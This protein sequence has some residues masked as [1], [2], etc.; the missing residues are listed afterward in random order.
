MSY[1]SHLY[2]EAQCATGAVRSSALQ[3]VFRPRLPPWATHS[4]PDI[5]Q[6]GSKAPM[7]LKTTHLVDNSSHV[8][9][10]L[11]ASSAAPNA[12]QA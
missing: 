7:S 3:E 11:G 1:P 2:P 5:F 4:S 8:P 6:T 12:T 10:Q 9:T